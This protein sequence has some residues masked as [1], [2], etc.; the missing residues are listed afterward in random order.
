MS[1]DLKTFDKRTIFECYIFFRKKGVYVTLSFYERELSKIPD[2]GQYMH[3]KP[4]YTKLVN[5]LK[6]ISKTPDNDIHLEKRVVGEGPVDAGE[7]WGIFVDFFMCDEYYTK[8]FNKMIEETP[9]GIAPYLDYENI[10][11]K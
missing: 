7:S 11:I 5:F 1:K 9:F 3:V 10:K 6:D 4:G 2:K 8:K